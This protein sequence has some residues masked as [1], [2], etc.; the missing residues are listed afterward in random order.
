MTIQSFPRAGILRAPILKSPFLRVPFFRV[1]PLLLALSFL[2]ISQIH[3]QSLGHPLPAPPPPGAKSAKCTKR[4]IPQ[5]QDVTAKAGITFS[6]TSSKDKK[7]IFESMT[8]G[9]II[10][11]Y[12]RDGWPDIY[13]TNSPTVDMAQAGKTSPRRSLSQQSRRHIY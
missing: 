13:F 2:A 10:F 9:V 4:P 12:D 7:F 1:L 5:L 3:S 6:H 11:D 8:G